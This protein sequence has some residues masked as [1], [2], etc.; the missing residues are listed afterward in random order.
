VN[1]VFRDSG[2]KRV[3]RHGEFPA[4]NIWIKDD[5]AIL[6]AELPGIDPEKIDI[7]VKDD[8]VTVRGE[9][10]AAEL[11]ESEAY[12]RQERG[13]GSFLRS[14]S[15]PFKV[16]AESV[17]AQYQKGVLQVVLPRAEADKPKRIA[18]AAA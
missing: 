11:G 16:D 17:S 1:H 6:A 2:G 7:T 5:D 4:V 14:F 13:S 10:E 12:L 3:S 9:R 8:T 18:I 15:L